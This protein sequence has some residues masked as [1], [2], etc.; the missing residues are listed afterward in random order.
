MERICELETELE[1][2]RGVLGQQ[3]TRALEEVDSS[4]SI[5]FGHGA[6]TRGREQAAATG[7]KTRSRVVDALYLGPVPERL[8]E[9]VAEQLLVLARAAPATSTSQAAKRSCSSR[10]APSGSSRTPPRGSAR[11][12]RKSRPLPRRPPFGTD[13]LLA[14]ERVQTR[15]QPARRALRDRAD[16]ALMEDLALHGRALDHVSLVALQPV[17]S[18]G[19]ER[20]GW[21]APSAP[22]TDRPWPPS[23][24]CRGAAARRPSAW[25]ASPRRRAGYL[26]PPPECG[27]SRRS[28]SVA[29]PSRFSISSSDWP[30]DRGSRIR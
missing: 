17:E 14:D 28:S 11:A 3:R 27:T 6:T 16:G 23:G 10:E 21:T 7:G 13:E 22:R 30:G 26:R 18:G 15:S 9:V 4:G 8:L 1:P 2:F 20:P 19:D 12:G 5:S 24:R 29:S 25:T